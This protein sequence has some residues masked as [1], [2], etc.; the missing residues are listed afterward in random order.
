M[1][2]FRADREYEDGMSLEPEDLNSKVPL[3]TH[4]S[5]ASRSKK[6]KTRFISTTKVIGIAAYKYALG[7]RHPSDQRRKV[8]LIDIDDNIE[9]YDFSD[10]EVLKKHAKGHS[11]TSFVKA[12]QE[13]TI[14]GSVPAKNVKEVPP[15]LVDVLYALQ[16]R[17]AH[18]KYV[19]EYEIMANS[20]MTKIYNGEITQESI[21]KIIDKMPFNDFEKSF[22]QSYYG[23]RDKIEV[24]AEKIIAPKKGEDINFVASCVKQQIV[25]TFIKSKEFLDL[26]PTI[27]EINKKTLKHSKPGEMQKIIDEIDN[28]VGINEYEVSNK[29]MC[30]T[31][32]KKLLDESYRFG[33]CFKYKISKD[34]GKRK[35]PYGIKYDGTKY[36]PISTKMQKS[37][38]GRQ[39]FMSAFGKLVLFEGIEFP[40]ITL[41]NV[42]NVMKETN[43]TERQSVA[44]TVNKE[45]NKQIDKKQEQI[46]QE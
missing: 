41:N 19:Q 21:N 35:Q 8:L 28:F 13:V 17:T 38:L 15:I 40:I 3:S 7:Y 29:E 34:I 22:I 36:K 37:D 24:T 45:K 27:E 33:G 11:A 43:P 14:E 39:E 2:V 30:A 5:V 4:I 20:I 10:P 26:V 31:A 44:T 9:K 23:N 6:V 32:P 42:K 12:D 1:F 18:G 16:D 25:R 46:V